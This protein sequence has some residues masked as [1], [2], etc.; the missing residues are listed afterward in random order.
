MKRVEL[1]G[2]HLEGTTGTPLVLLREDDAPH[3]ILPIFVG[4]S[5][6]VA[7][8]VA[9]GGEQ[10]Q[11]PLTHDVMAAL[12][13]QLDARVDALEVT[14]LSDGAFVASLA[15]TGP[16][17]QQRVD[18]RP[19]DGIALAMRVGAP[20][21]VSEAVLD[22]AGAVVADDLDGDLDDDALDEETIDEAVAEFRTF[23]DD[24]DPADFAADIDDE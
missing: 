13:Q 11:R 22:E 6:A 15:L 9:L 10:P 1:V 23:L 7:I 18:T 16:H 24:L 17:G 5:E 20:L 4:A 14:E 21:F 8:A 12:V 19:S 3:R 2:L